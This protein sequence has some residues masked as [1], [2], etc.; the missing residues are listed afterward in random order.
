MFRQ[1]EWSSSILQGAALIKG[2]QPP[3]FLQWQPTI[4]WIASSDHSAEFYCAWHSWLHGLLAAVQ[5]CWAHPCWCHTTFSVTGSATK[6]CYTAKFTKFH[7]LNCLLWINIIPSYMLLSRKTHTSL[8]NTP[9]S[10]LLYHYDVLKLVYILQW[11]IV[12]LG[13]PVFYVYVRYKFK[14][15]QTLNILHQ[16]YSFFFLACIE[17]QIF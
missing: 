13:N 4:P 16:N 3:T 2:Q 1:S 15:N 11:T 14:C 7:I 8:F 9:F 17:L 10:W 6:F 5:W 12:T